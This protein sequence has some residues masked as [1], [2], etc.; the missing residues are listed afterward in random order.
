MTGGYTATG[1]CKNG[2]YQERNKGYT[3]LG[4]GLL[5]GL[6][7]RG[8]GCLWYTPGRKT[9]YLD[10]EFDLTVLRHLEA[11]DARKAGEYFDA[12]RPAAEDVSQQMGPRGGASTGMPSFGGPPGGTREICHWVG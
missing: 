8:F 9:A 12:Y 7:K 10:E 3:Q 5:I 4:V 6:M 2:H 1:H 11:G